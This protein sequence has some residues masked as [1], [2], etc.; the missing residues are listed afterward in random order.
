M[1]LSTKSQRYFQQFFKNNLEECLQQF[2]FI[3]VEDLDLTSNSAFYIHIL[4][5]NRLR[6]NEIDSSFEEDSV[7]S[8]ENEEE[9]K[10]I[11]DN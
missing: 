5:E 7:D 3:T 2:P 9:R 4:D 6:E 11:A 8:S 10:L 1:S